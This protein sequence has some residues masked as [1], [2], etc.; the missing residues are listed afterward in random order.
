MELI[1][2]KTIETVITD[3]ITGTKTTINSC[4]W[5]VEYEGLEFRRC[6]NDSGTIWHQPDDTSR[7]LQR[8]MLLGGGTGTTTPTPPKKY[9][10]NEL[11]SN[12]RHL[13]RNKKLE[14]I[15]K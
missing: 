7:Y 3:E 10:D 9:D 1:K 14:R 11:E 12:F 5:I 2:T 15:T 13:I 4:E 6:I 8:M